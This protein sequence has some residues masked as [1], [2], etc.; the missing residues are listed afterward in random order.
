VNGFPIWLVRR[1]VRVTGC[2]AF[3]FVLVHL[4][5]VGFRQLVLELEQLARW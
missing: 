2:N 5:D 3:L 1:V 4:I